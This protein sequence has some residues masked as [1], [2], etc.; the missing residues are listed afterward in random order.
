MVFQKKADGADG[1]DRFGGLRLCFAGCNSAGAI[2]QGAQ[3]ERHKGHRAQAIG[4]F[5][6][7]LAVARANRRSTMAAQTNAQTTD[8]TMK[9][10]KKMP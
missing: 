9:P 4:Q 1:E 6:P 5:G 10:A 8:D 7:L 3:R 2:P